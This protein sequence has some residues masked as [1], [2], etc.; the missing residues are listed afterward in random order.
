MP[1]KSALSLFVPVFFRAVSRNALLLGIRDRVPDITTYC[2]DALALRPGDP[3]FPPPA[4]SPCQ[5]T[6][7]QGDQSPCCSPLDRRA[8]QH[9]GRGHRQ[10]PAHCSA[11]SPR[12]ARNC[13]VRP[14][15]AGSSSPRYAPICPLAHGR[16]PWVGD[17]WPIEQNRTAGQANVKTFAAH[18]SRRRWIMNS[19]PLRE[20]G[21]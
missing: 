13:I 3:G 16:G 7:R 19:T 4:G 5:A 11:S 8:N 15:N 9:N 14:I 6:W 2:R 20:M 1:S 18:C 21:V 12:L 17:P 10:H